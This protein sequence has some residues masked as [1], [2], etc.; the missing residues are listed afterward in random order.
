V[1]PAWGLFEGEAAIG[2][3]VDISGSVNRGDILK[4]NRLM[5]KA[6]DTVVIQTGGGGG[7]GNPF[8]RD[9]EAVAQ[10]VREGSIS[11]E[12]AQSR[13]GVVLDGA[14]VDQAATQALRAAR[15]VG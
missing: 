9:P 3:H 5:L 14:A 15:P 13:Y 8:E 10:D 7:W 12:R 2:P 6:G 1:T 4:V 11:A